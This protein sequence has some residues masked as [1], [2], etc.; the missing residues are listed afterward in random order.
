[1]PVTP[2]P[3]LGD[4]GDPTISITSVRTGSAKNDILDKIGRTTGWTW[5]RVKET[6]KDV[7][8]ETG[9]VVECADE[10]DFVT[11]SGDSGAPV[12]KYTFGYRT[13][14]FRGIVFGYYDFRR[15]A[16]ARKG[17]FQDLEQI[18]RDLGR[19]GR[20]R[21]FSY[22]WSG[23]LHGSGS[24]ITGVVEESRWLRVTVTDPFERTASDS[25]EVTVGG[26]VPC[27]ADDPDDPDDSVPGVP[28]PPGS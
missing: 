18:K 13:A 15:D 3:P 21:P 8:G 16:L 12:F 25:L 20:L 17:L 19:L 9:V 4:S 10:V 6:C 23:V 1:M 14:Q 7:R 11:G 27:G 28:Q 22:E 5:G 24:S 2:L 26:V